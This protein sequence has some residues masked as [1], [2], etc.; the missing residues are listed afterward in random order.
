MVFSS[1]IFLFYF[2]PIV[3]IGYF[4]LKKWRKLSNLFLT[5]MSLLF[6]AWGEPRFV[7]IMMGSILVN[8]LFGLWVDA[9]HR[10]GRKGRYIIALMCAFNL[11]LLGV[12]KY[13]AF[14]VNSV[15]TLFGASFHI[16]QIALPIGISFFT[17][18]A[19][20]Y[21][22]DVYR[23]HG[24]V[25]RNLVNVC[26]YISFF[27]QLIAGPIVRYQT[28]AQEITDRRETFSDF[29]L[30][31]RRFMVGLC[32]KV[33]LA[34]QLG[35]LVDSVYGLAEGSMSTATAW[36]AACAYLMQVYYDFSGY[37]DMA[38]GLGRMFGFHFLENFDHPWLSRSVTGFWRRW[39]ISMCTWFRDYL[40][41]PL[42]GSRV[43]SK[44][45]LLFNLFMVWFCTGLWHG[46]AWTYVLW[47]LSFFLLQAIERE[48]GLGAWMEKRAFPGIPYAMIMLVI[49][50]VLIRS[51]SVAAA[52]VYYR[53]MF[54][55]GAVWDATAAMLV[56]E[57]GVFLLC[58]VVCGFPIGQWLTEKAGVPEGVIQ[59]GGA[60]ACA[61]LTCIA[62]SY[63]VVGSYNPFIY[64]NF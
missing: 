24:A 23:G 6:Y 47:G 12:F 54:G 61:A 55:G 52:G 14:A 3:L 28:V 64:F 41:F 50:T 46:A 26:L 21:V 49:V 27:P 38:I 13:L 2:L 42:G 63:I 15:N 48:T 25:Q 4:A 60:I 36:I 51:E 9:T 37:S 7:F 32:K 19:M 44:A 33:L 57:Y 34:N 58:G 8:Y 1:K 17:F 53:V 39:H 40:Y 29:T 22:I 20:S 43:K 31:C 5:G 10:K 30:G 35:L 56:R 11:G 18:Q 59:I 45:R 62:V 16:S